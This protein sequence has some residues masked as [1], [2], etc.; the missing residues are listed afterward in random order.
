MTLP[1]LKSVAASHRCFPSVISGAMVL[2]TAQSACIIVNA[3]TCTITSLITAPSA[4]LASSRAS[5]LM[6][7]RGHVLATRHS[8]RG[9]LCKQMLMTGQDGSSSFTCRWVRDLCCVK[10]LRRGEASRHLLLSASKPSPKTTAT[11]AY[12]RP[13][14]VT[15]TGNQSKH[16]ERNNSMMSTHIF[17]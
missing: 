3:N 13:G 9:H 16:A 14:S 8:H 2:L 6:D 15:P 7:A 10:E 11:A 12:K 4:R 1:G 17:V 5:S